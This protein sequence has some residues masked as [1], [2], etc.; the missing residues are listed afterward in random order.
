MFSFKEKRKSN[1]LKNIVTNSLKKTT[2][3][4][5]RKLNFPLMKSFL[6][7]GFLMVRRMQVYLPFKVL[8]SLP[9]NYNRIFDI[10]T[11]KAYIMA[12]PEDKKYSKL[13]K[14]A[15]ASFEIRRV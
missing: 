15:F 6:L 8:G 11:K 4:I 10:M 2:E 9:T 14:A 7:N 5:I 1:L 12:H 13:E 3:I